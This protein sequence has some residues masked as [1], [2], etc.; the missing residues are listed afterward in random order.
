MMGQNEMD[1]VE[2]SRVTD[3]FFN[4]TRRSLLRVQILE[5]ATRHPRQWT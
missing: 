1:L 3:M 4:V 5:S 2:E